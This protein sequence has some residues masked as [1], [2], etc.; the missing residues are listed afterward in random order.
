MPLAA[1]KAG[2]SVGRGNAK[3]TAHQALNG[4]KILKSADWGVGPPSGGMVYALVSKTNGL[5]D[6]ESSSL[7][8][9]TQLPK[10]FYANK[11]RK[12]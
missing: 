8:G 5:C 4:K 10:F 7:S 9:A 11:P 6:R 2:L 3:N 12:I 1:C